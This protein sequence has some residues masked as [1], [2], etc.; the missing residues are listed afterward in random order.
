MINQMDETKEQI[1][2]ELES[3][4]RDCGAYREVLAFCDIVGTEKRLHVEIFFE[5]SDY[6]IYRYDGKHF[7]YSEDNMFEKHKEI[8][9]FDDNADNEILGLLE[10][11][12]EKMMEIA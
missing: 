9:Q 10:T 8:E 1:L 4:I 11:Y 12:H 2:E 5:K 7:E 6:R 3:E